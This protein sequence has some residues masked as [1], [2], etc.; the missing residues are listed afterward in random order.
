MI[1]IIICCHNK[2]NFTRACVN[3]LLKLNLDNNEIIVIDNAS[4]DETQ[5]EL[6]QIKQ[7][8][9][10]RN[11][12]NI[13]HSAACNQGYRISTGNYVI[14]LNNDVRVKQPHSWT[15]MLIERCDDGLVGPS[16]GQLNGKLDFVQEANNTLFG[17]SYLSGWMIAASKSTWN[18]LDLGNGMIW[19]ERYPFYFNDTD[20]SFRAR[21]AGIPMVVI[22]VP[23]VHFGKISATQLNI[24]SLYTDARK[25]FVEEWKDLI[26]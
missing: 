26:Q 2:Y 14:F 9:Y 1:S 5:K 4:T 11:E 10:I 16:M 12:T 20:L 8:K 17:Y 3:D 21:E 25:V 15:E 13:F 22:D 7:I 19:N 18:K 24:Q 6:S 23:V